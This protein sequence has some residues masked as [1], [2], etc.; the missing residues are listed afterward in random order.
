LQIDRDYFGES[1]PKVAIC[2]NSI[3]LVYAKQGKYA[4][5]I[6]RYEQAL[7]I[8]WEYHGEVHPDVA[9]VLF[10]LGATL[11]EQKKYAAAM[12]KLEQALQ[13]YNHFL[14]EAHPTTKNVIG[15]LEH[16]RE[17]AKQAP[18]SKKE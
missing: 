11:V 7:Q 3:G 8:F 1:H 13:I 6:A 16:A 10:S 18:T 17:Q 4:E 5:A 12:V 15:W 9:R 2:L 14:G